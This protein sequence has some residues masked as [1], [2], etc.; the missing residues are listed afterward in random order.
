M[1]E[2]TVQSDWGDGNRENG[3]VAVVR[4]GGGGG[5]SGRH[6]A[7]TVINRTF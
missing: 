2:N 5:G 6:A 7:T 3:R 4:D 1:R